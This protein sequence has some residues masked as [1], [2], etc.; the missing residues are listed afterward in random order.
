MEANA[1]L[2]K[3][4]QS[5]NMTWANLTPACVTGSIDPPS[6][7]KWGWNV[8]GCDGGANGGGTWKWMS[9]SFIS[10]NRTSLMDPHWL[11]IDSSTHFPPPWSLEGFFVC[12]SLCVCVAEWV[13]VCVKCWLSDRWVHW[14]VRAA[15]SSATY[16]K[17]G[18]HLFPVRCWALTWHNTLLN[19]MLQ[20]FM[21]NS[22]VCCG[23]TLKW[24]HLD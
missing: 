7:R 4:L 17:P 1:N 11:W 20:L 23:F 21:E 16:S 18:Q 5:Q 8:V 22:V 12:V 9:L 15:L 13:N 3:F 10:V 6:A 2:E 14:V 19:L 24:F